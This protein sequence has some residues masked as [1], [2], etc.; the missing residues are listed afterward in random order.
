M[1]LARDTLATSAGLALRRA[2]RPL[3]ELEFG[4]GSSATLLRQRPATGVRQGTHERYMLVAVRL[5][6]FVVRLCI[7]TEANLIRFIDTRATGQQPGEDHSA[8]AIIEV[9]RR[10]HREHPGLVDIIRL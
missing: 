5:V 10:F 6:S 4:G 3:D 7:L 1:D 9:Q 2:L 8:S